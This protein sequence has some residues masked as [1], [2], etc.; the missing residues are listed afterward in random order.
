MIKLKSVS[1]KESSFPRAPDDEVVIQ[2]SLPVHQQLHQVQVPQSQAATKPEPGTCLDDLPLW[3][4]SQ[5]W[6]YLS[7][8]LASL[9]LY[10]DRFL[11]AYVSMSAWYWVL[12]LIP[13]H[14]QWRLSSS[15]WGGSPSSSSSSWSVKRLLWQRLPDL[16]ATRKARWVLCCTVN[17]MLWIP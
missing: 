13:S 14:A 17:P 4:T 5:Q 2:F 9:P 15:P 7:K 3:S 16:W 10:L 8:H 11:V 1:V 12:R 6:F